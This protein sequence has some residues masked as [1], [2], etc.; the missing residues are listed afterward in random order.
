MLGTLAGATVF[1]TQDRD[2]ARRD[3][4]DGTQQ[5]EGL[6]RQE[7]CRPGCPWPCI[8]GAERRRADERHRQIVPERRRSVRVRAMRRRHPREEDVRLP[9]IGMAAIVRVAAVALP[10]PGVCPRRASSRRGHT[11]GAC[12]GTSP[13][14]P[15]RA[16]NRGRQTLPS[17]PLQ[18]ARPGAVRRS[19]PS[20][21]GLRHQRAPDHGTDNDGSHHTPLHA[22]RMREAWRVRRA[23]RRHM[24]RR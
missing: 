15:D 11:D 20:S 10:G 12:G 7:R 3:A 22:L 2:R 9:V 4:G 16:T 17:L 19:R 21:H 6:D 5:D 23:R 14:S 1:T 18:P 24:P 8:G 13:P